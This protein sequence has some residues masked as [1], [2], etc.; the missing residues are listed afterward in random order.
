MVSFG[1]RIAA[2]LQAHRAAQ[3]EERQKW[4]SAYKESEQ[5]FTDEGGGPLPPWKSTRR[6]NALRA[7]AGL[8]E[9]VGLF[10]L[11]RTAATF[12]ALEGVGPL[13]VKEMLGH[14]RIAE[15][16]D[17]YSHVLATMQRDAAERLE[18]VLLDDEELASGWYGAPGSSSS[19]RPASSPP[20]KVIPTHHWT[21]PTTTR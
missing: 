16:M 15:V 11:R 17:R 3:H 4:G 14:K 9:V 2:L 10:S 8:G 7:R 19:S 5:V 12:A 20:S 21:T 1:G 13:D 18:S 6:F